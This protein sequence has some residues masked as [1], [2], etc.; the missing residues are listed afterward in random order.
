MHSDILRKLINE[1][2]EVSREHDGA[3]FPFSVVAFVCAQLN[4]GSGRD[5][6]RGEKERIGEKEEKRERKRLL[7]LHTQRN[8]YG[9]VKNFLQINQQYNNFFL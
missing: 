4:R 3:L 9:Y 8:F 2:L 5:R 6:K 1:L 7:R